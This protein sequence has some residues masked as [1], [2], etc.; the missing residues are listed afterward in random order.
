MEELGIGGDVDIKE[1]GLGASWIVLEDDLISLEKDPGVIR[2]IWLVSLH[3]RS[4]EQIRVH[5]SDEHSFDQN[6]DDT[7]LYDTSMAL[8]T[9]QQAYGLFPRVLGKGDGAQVSIP[10][11]FEPQR[12]VS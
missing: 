1:L 2:D 8:M 10:D 3:I 9:L 4:Y 12:E 7:P 5:N 6:G 11:V